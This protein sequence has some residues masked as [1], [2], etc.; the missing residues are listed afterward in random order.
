[1][2]SYRS[3]EIVRF[4]VPIACSENRAAMLDLSAAFGA[5]L[6][7]WPWPIQQQAAAGN[8]LRVPLIAYISV[9]HCPL[10][11][12]CIQC[13][14]GARAARVCPCSCSYML[15]DPLPAL[16]HLDRTERRHGRAGSQ[17]GRRYLVADLGTGRGERVQLERWWRSQTHPPHRLGVDGDGQRSVERSPPFEPPCTT[18]ST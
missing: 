1:V 10:C 14:L 2:T 17:S 16:R 6:T 9:D 5:L 8:Q 15:L 3:K 13:C 4:L 11:T 18:T 7:L 12:S